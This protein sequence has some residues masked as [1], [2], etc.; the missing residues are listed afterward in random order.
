M[1]SKRT[2]NIRAK[3]KKNEIKRMKIQ[4]IQKKITVVGVLGM[5]TL[6]IFLLF[7]YLKSPTQSLKL[8]F[9]LKQPQNTTQLINH[10]LTKIPTIDGEI[11]TSIEM[12]SQGAWVTSSQ[13]VFFTLIEANYKTNKISYK[14]Y[15]SDFDVTGSWTIE[16][17]KNENNTTLNFI[18]NSSIDNL[19][20]RALLYWTGENRYCEN[21]FEAF[22]NSF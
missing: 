5:L 11:A 18:E 3:I 22:K 20:Q 21:L 14:V 17:H 12:T 9:E 4:K 16:F 1:N 7:G 6:V 13:N 2:R 15:Q 8:S 19:G 10:F